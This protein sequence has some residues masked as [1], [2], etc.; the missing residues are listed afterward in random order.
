MYSYSD[1]LSKLETSKRFFKGA[2]FSLILMMSVA[3]SL[4]AVA[5]N[6]SINSYDCNESLPKAHNDHSSRMRVRGL[7]N[8]KTTCVMKEMYKLARQECSV[9]S[10]AGSNEK[11]SRLGRFNLDQFSRFKVWGVGDSKAIA[12]V[13]KSLRNALEKMQSREPATEEAQGQD[14]EKTAAKERIK[15][16]L[17]AVQKCRSESSANNDDYRE[18]KPG[19]SAE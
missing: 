12:G 13:E 11:K 3:W 1:F 4:S 17:I 7:N 2:A 8:D 14:D 10:K 9:R 19:D 15:K 16:S 5:E 6:D 18:L